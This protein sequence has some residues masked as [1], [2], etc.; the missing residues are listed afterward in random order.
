MGSA[1]NACA[2]V[3]WLAVWSWSILGSWRILR[4]DSQRLACR[5][6]R[7]TPHAD[8]RLD[9]PFLLPLHRFLRPQQAGSP[10]WRT[11]MWFPLGNFCYHSTSLC[12]R[13][14]TFA[15]QSLLHIVHQHVLH[16]WPASFRR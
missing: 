1:N 7:S 14:P 9:V 10:C 13:G 3:C 8:G 16:H 15:T 12:V 2:L 5:C 6:I 11:L 4:S